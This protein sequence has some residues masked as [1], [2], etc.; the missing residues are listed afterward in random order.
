M[1]N[2]K[3][4][5]PEKSANWAD[6]DN[7]LDAKHLLAEG[8]RHS[9]QCHGGTHEVHTECEICMWI[10]EELMK[11]IGVSAEDV[12]RLSTAQTHKE[13]AAAILLRQRDEEKRH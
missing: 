5:K 1:W 12:L 8:N 10:A 9:E 2:R 4:E 11:A 6:V 3:P 7:P 13:I